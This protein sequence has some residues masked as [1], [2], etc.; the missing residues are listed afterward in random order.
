[1]TPCLIDPVPRTELYLF[2]CF[3]KS[4]SRHRRCENIA[5][6]IIQRPAMTQIAGHLHLVPPRVQVAVIELR[7]VIQGEMLSQIHLGGTN[8]IGIFTP[9]PRPCRKQRRITVKVV[10]LSDNIFPL[11]SPLAVTSCRYPVS[12]PAAVFDAAHSGNAHRTKPT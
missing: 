10:A 12:P 4:R 2:T 5:G 6:V 11:A 3:R 1:R 7:L 8:E 9:Q